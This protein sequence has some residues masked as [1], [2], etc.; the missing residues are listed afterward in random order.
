MHMTWALI[1]ATIGRV[2]PL[3]KALASISQQIDQ[4]GQPLTHIRIIVIDQNSDDRLIALITRW[5]SRL[6]IEHI[7]IQPRGVSQ[8]RNIGLDRLTNE[9]FV[10]FPD[11]DAFFSPTT[12]ANVEHAFASWPNAGI[13]LGSLHLPEE[14]LFATPPFNPTAC[15]RPGRIRLLYQAGMPLQFFRREALRSAGRFDESLGPGNG[16]PWLCG[17]DSDLL[18]RAFD[19]GHI[20]IRVPAVRIFHP[21]VDASTPGYERKAF[22]YG[23]GRMRL[24]QKNRYPL[25]FKIASV[26]HPL[27]KCCSFKTAKRRFSLHLFRGR[28][29]ELLNPS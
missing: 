8:A 26:L 21:A 1:I 3:E 28:L 11:D 5:S 24:L 22:G 16:T 10:C 19:A 17:E 9:D 12:L 6:R 25:W 7:R 23:R 18:I 15:T 2:D 20:A 27:A 13:V 29:H 4:Q 14:S